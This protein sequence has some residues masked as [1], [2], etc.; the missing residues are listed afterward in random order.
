MRRRNL[1]SGI[2]SLAII[3]VFVFLSIGIVPPPCAKADPAAYGIENYWQQD[4]SYSIN[5]SLDTDNHFLSGREKVFYRNNSPDTLRRFYMHL[6]PNA[7]REKV[8][9]LVRDFMK[10]TMF[11]FVGLPE[12]MRGW[13]DIDTLMVDGKGLDFQVDGTILECELPEPLLPGDSITIDLSFREKIRRRVGRAGYMGRHYDIAQWY[14]KMVVYDRYG[15]HPDQLRMGEFYGEFATYDVSIT[16]PEDYIIAATGEPV[17]GDPGWERAKS[18]TGG[19]MSGKAGSMMKR[20]HG[21]GAPKK[22]NKPE[23]SKTVRFHAENVHDFALVADPTFVMEDTLYNGVRIMSFYRMWNRSWKDSVLAR[24]VRTVKWLESIAGPFPY[25]LLYVVDSPTRGGMEY[26]MLVMNGGTDEGL[27]LHEVGHQYFY[28]CLANDERREAWLDEG[29]TQF[30]TFWYAEEHYGPYGTKEDERPFPYNLF[31]RYRMWEGIA[32]PVIE[33]KRQ[34]YDERIATPAQELSNYTMMEYI[35]APL[36]LRALRYMVG[37]DT[38]REIL[39]TYYERWKF[40]HVDEESFL[41]VC[42]EL[43]GMDLSEVFRQWL[44]STKDC[45]YRLAKFK[46]SKGGDGY[47]AKVVIERKGEVMMPLTLAFRL[48]NGNTVTR[49]VDGFLRTIE[50]EFTFSEKPLSVAI[51]P[52]NEI[53]D[54]YLLD[55]FYPR[56]RHFTL[57]LPFNDYHPQD[58]FEYRFLPIGYYNDIDGGKIGLRLRGGYDDYYRKFTLQA[59]YGFE[60]GKVDFYASLEHPLKYFGRDASIYMDG[61]AREGRQGA[62]LRINKIRR[63]YLHDPL[64]KHL[65]FYLSYNELIDSSYVYEKTYSDGRNLKGGF[66]LAIYPRTDIFSSSLEVLA[67]RSI[68]GSK[69]NYEKLSIDARISPSRYYPLPLKLN[70]RFFYGRTTMDPPLQERFHLA[71]AGTAARERYFWL[72]SVGAFPGDYYNNFHLPGDGNLRGYFDADFAFKELF[73]SNI[74]LDLP[75]PFPGGRGFRRMIKPRL[76]LFYD[77]G[78][79]MDKRPMEAVPEGSDFISTD[80]NPF[81]SILYDFGVGIKV[82]KF[83]INLPLYLSEPS[84]S[85]EKEKWKLRWT[86]G[87]SGLF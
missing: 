45:D 39:K 67:D 75:V 38:F 21:S 1:P 69:Y 56:R 61:Y 31:P 82:W 41:S 71:G 17:E 40:K 25:R 36:F 85:G 87:F 26:P 27:I 86:V 18:E 22:E 51:N 63:K 20:R 49:F 47:R 37:E 53:L 52:D 62:L 9:Q 23:K 68:L 24:T 46:V 6:Y 11:F 29:F 79:V 60:S 32:R 3:I 66:G 12:S 54:I 78:K 4:V 16:L 44:H 34:G 33:L 28:G 8:P 84:L 15:W 81:D 80:E 30:Q 76:Y 2:V 35:K 5:V 83:H 13:I 55:N 19:A 64:A 70:L 14:P 74:E 73:A 58:A 72:R 10:G 77:W 7:Y 57:D 59:L 43:S 65:S 48:K 50:E 42:E